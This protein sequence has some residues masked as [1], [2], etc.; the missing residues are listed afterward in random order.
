MERAVAGV[1]GSLEAFYF[2]FGRDDVYL[3]VDLPNHSAAMAMAGAVTTSGAVENYET[4]VLLSPSEV[5]EAMN[6]AV[7]YSP[8]GS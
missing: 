1:G 5:D 3:I 4:V 7:D 8:P 6:V 2:A